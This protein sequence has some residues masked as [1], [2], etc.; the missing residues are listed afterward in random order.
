VG[1]LR[2]GKVVRVKVPANFRLQA[3][4]DYLYFV[5]NELQR[6]FPK[7]PI[8]AMVDKATG[9]DVE[10]VAQLR[11]VAVDLKRQKA[12][13]NRVTGANL[14]TE[15]EDVILTATSAQTGVAQ[16]IEKGKLCQ[17]RCQS[18]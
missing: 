14:G 1:V 16:G 7:S 13:W 12:R 3:R 6:S 17:S 4:I 5:L 11:E 2:K 18:E 9:Y 15:M 10:R 8:D